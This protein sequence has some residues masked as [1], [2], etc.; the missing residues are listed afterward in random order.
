MKKEK[1]DWHRSLSASVAEQLLVAFCDVAGHADPRRRTSR[2]RSRFKG[3]G[4]SGSRQ[5]GTTGMLAKPY[6]PV[7]RTATRLAQHL[8][9]PIFLTNSKGR[10]VF[11]NRRCCNL[12]DW[13]SSTLLGNSWLAL[14]HHDDRQVVSARFQQALAART[15]FEGE[16]RRFPAAQ[17]TLCFIAQIFPVTSGA[18]DLLGCVGTL[19]D[20]THLKAGQIELIDTN[21]R[22]AAIIES[23]PFAIVSINR[24]G[25]VTQW[26]RRASQWFGWSAEEAIGSPLTIMLQ[27][28]RREF[29][30]FL[31]DIFGRNASSSSM[32]S[33]V[34]R[35]GDLMLARVTVASVTHP[36]APSAE[37]VLFLD[38]LTQ[39][40]SANAQLQ[41]LFERHERYLSD[42]HDGFMQSLYGIGIGL[43]QC[44][45]TV[46]R[47]PARA[48]NL[49]SQATADINLVLQEMRETLLE[50]GPQTLERHD[51]DLAIRRILKRFSGS[52][53]RFELIVDP[54]A[55][56]PP[57]TLRQ[58]LEFI[59]SEGISNVVKHARA[60]ICQ[61]SLSLQGHRVQLSIND[62]G[63][64]F[65]P[66]KSGGVG[67]GLQNIEARVHELGGRFHLETRPGAGTRLTV[68][69]PVK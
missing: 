9:F 22:L 34:S 27:S 21:T 63:V 46:A 17:R 24:N 60:V 54:P 56:K 66:T 31:A 12:I 30:D 4:A 51:L 32:R 52:G 35:A 25:N 37:A 7:A 8:P 2:Y 48:E 44:R 41:A 6:P 5:S 65:D 53:P 26:N 59:A 45:L 42:M 69:F 15:P 33:F 1:Y 50:N 20:V 64:G 16:F 57:H 3:L 18:G 13:D 61:I 19:A 58:H 29:Q 11:S 38:D 49:L 28:G 67:H 47:D 10:V 39:S 55:A 40:E 43:E 14:V 36:P 62:D 68:D 23:S